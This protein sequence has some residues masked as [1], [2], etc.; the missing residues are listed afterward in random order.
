MVATQQHRG[1]I[2]SLTNVIGV[3]LSS[4]SQISKEVVSF[5]QSLFGTVDSQVQGCPKQLL[6]AIFQTSLPLMLLPICSNQ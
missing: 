5:F 2:T 3:K 4:F 6:E 1:I